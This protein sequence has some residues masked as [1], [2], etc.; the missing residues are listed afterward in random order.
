MS[1][2]LAS[3]LSS[4]VRL[5]KSVPPTSIDD[6][7]QSGYLF[8]ELL[9]K[10]DVISEVD[11]NKQFKYGKKLDK[12]SSIEGSVENFTVLHQILSDKLSIKLS[13][14]FAFDLIMGKP[15]SAARLLYQ[16]K[17]YIN[18]GIL[19]GKISESVIGAK[20]KV[21]E[22][23]N[24]IPKLPSLHKSN[25]QDSNISNSGIGQLGSGRSTPMSS[26]PATPTGK[27]HVYNSLNFNTI[28]DAGMNAPINKLVSATSP[29]KKYND[30]E[31]EF[32]ADTLKAKLRRHHRAGYKPLDHPKL[33]HPEIDYDKLLLKKKLK[34]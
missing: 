24:T 16:I 26:Y 17:S 18:G 5:S 25:S 30:K 27:K 32:F 6:M 9:W 3:W 28:I 22:G 21:K 13:P 19:R 33:E 1:A 29:K 12:N 7:F 15:G 4:D 10:L 11:F 23:K 31:H 8:G 2:I 34:V 14:N 20:S